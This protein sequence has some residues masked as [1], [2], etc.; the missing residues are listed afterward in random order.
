MVPT[1]ELF[2]PPTHA[3]LEHIK[4]EKWQAK[5]KGIAEEL[6]ASLEAAKKAGDVVTSF[7]DWGVKEY[8]V[9]TPERHKRL[10]MMLKITPTDRATMAEVMKHSSWKRIR[11][12]DR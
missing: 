5:L 6:E 10:S 9:L 4:D 8:P 3:F 1:F 7:E 12:R 2:G 11:A